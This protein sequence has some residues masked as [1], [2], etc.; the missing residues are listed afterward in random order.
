MQKFFIRYSIN[1]VFL[2]LHGMIGLHLI[3]CHS[4][5]AWQDSRYVHAR[6][7]VINVYQDRV[8]MS[9]FVK[10]KLHNAQYEDG[11]AFYM[12][13]RG[14]EDLLYCKKILRLPKKLVSL[15]H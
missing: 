3:I 15:I 5:H 12:S 4:F 6:Y 11:K 7:D 9:E 1:Y 13:T 8:R 2:K 10:K 14:E